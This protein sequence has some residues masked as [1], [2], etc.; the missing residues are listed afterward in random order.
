[1]PRFFGYIGPKVYSTLSLGSL[2]RT[3][4]GHNQSSLNK[5]KNDMGRSME[6]LEHKKSFLKRPDDLGIPKTCDEGSSSTAT[7][8]SSY[9][10][11]SDD[12]ADNL[13]LERGLA[14]DAEGSATRRD[15]LETGDNLV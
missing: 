8:K 6:S 11:L 14:A 15:G 10:T 7:N 4:L 3:L 2:I 1:M 5:K 13:A 12:P 9:I